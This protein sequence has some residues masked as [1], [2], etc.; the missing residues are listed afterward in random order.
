AAPASIAHGVTEKPGPLQAQVLPARRC[1]RLWEFLELWEFSLI[2]NLDFTF[3]NR[4]RRGDI[5]LVR[6]SRNIVIDDRTRRIIHDLDAEFV[7]AACAGL[8]SIRDCHQEGV[9]SSTIHLPRTLELRHGA[10]NHKRII[11]RALKYKLTLR[12]GRR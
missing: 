3:C 8:T 11:R 5:D 10:S 6:S 12:L 1:G 9:V 4:L 2:Y 7:A